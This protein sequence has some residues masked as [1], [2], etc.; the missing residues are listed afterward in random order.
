MRYVVGSFMILLWIFLVIFLSAGFSLNLSLVFVDFA[1]IVS[2]CI[3]IAAVIF[4]TGESKAYIAAINA[5]L[6]KKYNISATDK[7]KAIRLFRLLGKSVIASAFLI[8]IIGLLIMLA[9]F[10]LDSLD[11]IGPS[12]AMSLLSIFYGA[13]INLIFIY[14]AIY[15]LET[16]D[17]MEE[18]ALISERQVIDKMLELCYKQGISPE[19]IINASEISFKKRQ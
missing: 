7:D 6:S 5:L 2:F 16:R 8:F 10:S 12:L 18:K 15:V 9:N 13:M 17:N 14:P 11:A 4:I 1:N 19:D 3:V